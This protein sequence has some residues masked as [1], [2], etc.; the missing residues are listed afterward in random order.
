LGTVAGDPRY[1]WPR[2]LTDLFERKLMGEGSG[3]I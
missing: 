1:E 2:Y 3:G